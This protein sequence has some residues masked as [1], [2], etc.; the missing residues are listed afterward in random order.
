[1]GGCGFSSDV[2]H[3]PTH[4]NKRSKCTVGLTLTQPLTSKSR[5]EML[6][7]FVSSRSPMSLH[8][9]PPVPRPPPRPRRPRPLFNRYRITTQTITLYPT[10]SLCNQLLCSSS[11]LPMI[12]DFWPWRAY[13]ACTDASATAD[14]FFSSCSPLCSTYIYPPQT[15]SPQLMTWPACTS[16]SFSVPPPHTQSAV[17]DLIASSS[18][19]W[20]HTPTTTPT[21]SPPPP[22]R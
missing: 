6:S 3:P 8:T 4:H 16:C 14:C 10:V 20:K 17:R 2:S 1:V 22:D 9:V 21:P 18:P 5:L 7:F 13:N 19:T 11:P 12:P 15:P